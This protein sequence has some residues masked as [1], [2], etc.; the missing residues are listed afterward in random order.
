MERAVRCHLIRAAGAPPIIV[1]VVDDRADDDLTAA[2]A[3][4][5][6]VPSPRFWGVW[7]AGEGGGADAIA[8]RLID[9]DGHRERTWWLDVF[10]PPLLGAI[11]EVPHVVVVQP[12]EIADALK[13]T[14][15]TSADVVGLVRSLRGGLFV[16]VTEQSDLVRELHGH[17]VI[18]AFEGSITYE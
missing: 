9:R 3:S 15:A 11:L 13:L 2:F 6:A 7:G 1:W 12:R 16:R 8:F 18:G 5:T 17:K 4:E 14:D 10:G